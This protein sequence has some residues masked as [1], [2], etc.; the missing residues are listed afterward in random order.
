MKRRDALDAL[1]ELCQPLSRL[2]PADWTSAD[3]RRLGDALARL[4]A[5]R[6]AYVMAL[7]PDDRALVGDALQVCSLALPR[8]DASDRVH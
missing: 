7:G 5:E 1:E 3:F 8:L 6:R 2:P 4:V